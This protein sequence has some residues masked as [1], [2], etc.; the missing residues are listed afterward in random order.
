LAASEQQKREE[1]SSKFENTIWE[2]KSKM[3]EDT[4]EKKK[5]AEDNELLVIYLTFLNFNFIYTNILFID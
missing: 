5:R 2:I 4:D 1:L 3:E